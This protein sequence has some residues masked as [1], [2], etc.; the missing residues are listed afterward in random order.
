MIRRFEHV[1]A[2]AEQ[3]LLLL[4]HAGIDLVGVDHGT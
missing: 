2:R 4:V 1:R 3:T